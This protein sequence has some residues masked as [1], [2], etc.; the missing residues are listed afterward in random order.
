MA[1]AALGP[2]LELMRELLA[3]L[4]PRGLAVVQGLS[5]DADAAHID[6][7]PAE[8]RVVAAT[9]GFDPRSTSGWLV[10]LYVRD[11]APPAL[12]L[13]LEDDLEDGAPLL[14]L[15]FALC[16]LAWRLRER[17]PLPAGPLRVEMREAIHALRNGLNSVV[18]S[19]AVL[20]SAML[21][22]DLRSF[23][24]DLDDAVGRSLQSLRHLSTL[25]SPE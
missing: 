9:A 22:A 2:W 5:M 20:N 12:L 16:R 17:Q 19:S 25:I 7:L 18:M 1:D 21:P 8:A 11:Q 3:A 6:R 10:R 13:A 4:A 24:N 23:G 15:G 14:V